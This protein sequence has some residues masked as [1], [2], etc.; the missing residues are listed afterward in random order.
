MPSMPESD[1]LGEAR[2]QGPKPCSTVQSATSC[3]TTPWDR[4]APPATPPF[5]SHDKRELILSLR[6]ILRISRQAL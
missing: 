5:L 3:I 2:V 1:Q 4:W 6:E